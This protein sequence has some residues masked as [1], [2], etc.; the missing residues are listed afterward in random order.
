MRERRK[1]HTNDMKFI[2]NVYFSITLLSFIFTIQ[3]IISIMFCLLVLKH[4]LCLYPFLWCV[5]FSFLFKLNDQ[6]G[7]SSLLSDV[8][9]FFINF[10]LVDLTAMLCKYFKDGTPVSSK[11]D[12]VSVF[13][14]SS[15]GQAA[16][17][18]R[19]IVS[20]VEVAA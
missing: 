3:A 5:F 20:A 9:F 13:F 7:T 6:D 2:V 15:S 1:T 8:F 4:S 18:L 11:N 16:Y 10:S 19:T 17:W 12:F 14:K